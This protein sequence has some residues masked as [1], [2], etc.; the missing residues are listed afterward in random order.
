MSNCRKI[1]SL[2][3]T[4][5]MVLGAFAV[6]PVTV[7]AADTAVAATGDYPQIK[8]GDTV[9]VNIENG[10]DS[11]YF[12]F[13]PE[14]DMYVSFF[15][16]DGNSTGFTGTYGLLYDA[17]MQELCSA[18]GGL[19]DDFQLT[20]A[21]EAGHTY[22]F[23]TSF[24]VDNT[25]GDF[26]VTL[27]ETALW[28]YAVLDEGGISIT[29][30]SGN[31]AEVDIPGTIDGYT[32]TAIGD[33]VFSGNKNLTS[34]T[35]PVSVTDIGDSAFYLCNNLESVT[36]PASVTRIGEYAFAYCDNLATIIIPDSVASIGYA[37]FWSTA[38]YNN[39]PDGLIYAGKVAYKMKGDTCP[40]EVIIKDGTI[41]IA[42]Y[43]FRGC[44]DLESITIPDSVLNIG[45]HAFYECT[46]LKS[47]VIPDS[48][49]SSIGA[50][51]FM[52]CTSLTDVT[53]GESVTTIEQTVFL[54]CPNLLSVTIPASVKTIGTYA[55][56]YYRDEDWNVV[57][58][59]GFTIT[60]Y[61]NTAAKRYAENNGISFTS[62]GLPPTT[63]TDI[64][65]GETKTAEITEA[66][67]IAYFRFVPDED[68]TVYFY[69]DSESD[70]YGYL[71]DESFIELTHN[72]DD[73]SERNFWIAYDVTA[74]KTYYF[75][76][77][78]Y[79][80]IT[81]SFDVI[82]E[83]YASPVQPEYPEIKIGETVT[84]NIEEEEGQATL[85]FIPE[86]SM[87]ICF[88][89]VGDKDTYGSLQD[90]KWDWISY[91][92]D[93]GAGENF[94]ITAKVTAGSV[95]YFVAEFSDSRETGSFDVVLEQGPDW[96][97]WVL[98]DGTIE[99]NRYNGGDSDL[100]IPETIDGYTV[101]SINGNAFA[102]NNDLTSV[103][104]P[105]SVT[106]IGSGAFQFCENLTSVT[107]PKHITWIAEGMFM[108]CSKLAGIT[109]PASVTSIGFMAFADCVSLMDITIPDTILSIGGSAFHN[110]AWYNS[111][112]DGVLYL[113]KLLYGVK[114]ECPSEVVVKDDTVRIAASAF[115]GCESLHRVIIPD[116]VTNIGSYAFS[117]CSELT[118][119]SI[120][121]N[122]TSIGAQAFFGC[123]ALTSITIPSCVTEIGPQAFGYYW[124]DWDT[125]IL[126]V[127]DF[128]I[129]GYTGTAAETYAN[130]K[131]F[132]F[133]PLDESAGST[134]SGTATSY[135]SD[136]DAVTIQLLQS[137]SVKYSAT[138]TGKSASYLIQN[139]AAGSYTLR[140]SKKNHVTRDY[141]VTV[142]GNTTQDV[143]ICPIGDADG[144]GRVNS[145]DAKAAFR[146]SNDEKPITDPYKFAC[147]DVAKPNNRV[148]SADAKAIF[149]HANEQKSLWME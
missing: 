35:I 14:K 137:D 45:H 51:S 65:P 140:V 78:F 11:V 110:T 7:S 72:D 4:F 74:G 55:F 68:M 40:A 70:T 50:Y 56:G 39:Q 41:G 89:S 83:K 15:S 139:V 146:H 88:Y 99:I 20:Y 23:K 121:N 69:S 30:Y 84:I 2:L 106:D 102:N 31:D 57:A 8:V 85:K 1:I 126:K 28:E 58:V 6:T 147:A 108:G 105:D 95:Y 90:E 122:V 125:G 87:A 47:I 133:I 98:Y 37:A 25:V 142:S 103:T 19:W 33:K 149:R 5:V 94:Q 100:I 46:G 10:G 138:V 129:Y 18:Y 141:A 113:G 24:Y 131:G 43:A 54:N 76:A 38:W 109:I 123:E 116:S 128:T 64:A 21:V 67:E 42:D 104:I 53:I 117:G 13:V 79:N 143:K 91:N 44:S 145:A 96:D 60:G 144:N 16:A 52:N 132:S 101:T 49:T 130:E 3:L 80:N 93:G 127:N 124:K 61:E 120:G 12:R 59:E 92:D 134:V 82:L 97:Y 114:N 75:G 136:T 77:K 17:D 119:V 34:V 73:G 66:G 107:L 32:V 36:I 81:G 48:V 29:A 135:L 22:Y 71:Y 148:N 63:Y 115:Q 86:K 62:L 112:P 118:D 9:T 27:S 26:T 111:Q